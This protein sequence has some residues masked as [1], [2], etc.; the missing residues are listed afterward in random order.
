VKKGR[1][2]DSDRKETAKMYDIADGIIG[3]LTM[4][5]GGKVPGRRAIEVT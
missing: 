5:C 4:E 2:R 3:H 1:L